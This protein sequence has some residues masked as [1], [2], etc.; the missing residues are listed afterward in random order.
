MLSDF[1]TRMQNVGSLLNLKRRVFWNNHDW[2]NKL[3]TSHKYEPLN[4]KWKYAEVEQS[5]KQNG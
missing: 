4:I 5:G 3:V 1:I 2:K